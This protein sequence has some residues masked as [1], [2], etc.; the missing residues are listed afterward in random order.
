MDGQN[1]VLYSNRS[2]AYAKAGKYEEALK[3]ANKTIEINST[4]PKGYSRKS[5][6]LSGMQKYTE[7]LASYKK[8]K[9]HFFAIKIYMWLSN[10]F[11]ISFFTLHI[12]INNISY[13]WL[14]LVIVIFLYYN[15]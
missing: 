2:A 6:A 12:F 5:A 14:I 8:G 11:C 7:A 13:V 9:T 1:H 4:W 15:N 3:D 10:I